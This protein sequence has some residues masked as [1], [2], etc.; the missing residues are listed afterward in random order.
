MLRKKNFCSLFFAALKCKN[1]QKKK[2]HLVK[3]ILKKITVFCL[4]L[5]VFLEE[6]TLSYFATFAVIPF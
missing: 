6:K 5:K 3:I 1:E 4:Y 2:K